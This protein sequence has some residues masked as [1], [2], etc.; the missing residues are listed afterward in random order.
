MTEILPWVPTPRRVKT[1]L[2]SLAERTCGL[3]F[4]MP[5]RMLDRGRGDGGMYYP[6]PKGILTQLLSEVDR[7]RFPRLLDVG[8]GKG[9]VLCQA[10]EMGFQADGVE[11]DEKMCRICRRNLARLGV[12]AR[13]YQ[14]DARAFQGY[15][16]YDLFYF[17]NPCTEAVLDRV[18]ERIEL[19]CRG[20]EVMLLYYHPR[21]PGAMER[22]G[23]FHRISEVFDG[24]KGYWA[25]TYRGTP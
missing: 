5:D 1:V 19:Q 15:G 22:S 20:R 8:C 10:R 13:V 11:Y 25:Y 17:F 23:V 9:A 3:D 24:E 4:T 14:A 21:Y 18:I 16:G 6:T 2:K 7:E 12:P